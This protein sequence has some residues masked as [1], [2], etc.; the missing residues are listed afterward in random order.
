MTPS[1]RSSVPTEI[2]M[3]ASLEDDIAH[4]SSD[5]ARAPIQDYLVAWPQC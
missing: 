3:L 1:T 2:P 4:G 5:N